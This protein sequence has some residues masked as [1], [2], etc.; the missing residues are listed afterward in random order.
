M[1]ALLIMAKAL[2][3]IR[4]VLEQVLI[5]GGLAIALLGWFAHNDSLW[6]HGS[7]WFLVGIMG[8]IVRR[9]D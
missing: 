9:L 5:W 2:F 3:A 6:V 8:N 1:K 4:I 7:I